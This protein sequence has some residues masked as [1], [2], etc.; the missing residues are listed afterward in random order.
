MNF[1]QNP[2]TDYRVVEVL[3]IFFCRVSHKLEGSI[4]WP[5]CSQGPVNVNIAHTTLHF[6][7]SVQEALPAAPTYHQCEAWRQSL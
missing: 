5:S 6:T 3:Q 4:F 2:T 1:P 7:S